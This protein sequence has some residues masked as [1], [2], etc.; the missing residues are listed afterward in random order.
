MRALTVWPLLMV[1]GIACRRAEQRA[2]AEPPIA[3]RDARA[4][5][6]VAPAP[7]GRDSGSPP[8]EA[9]RLRE[10]VRD[11]VERVTRCDEQFFARVDPERI[12][13][14]QLPVDVQAMEA[15]CDP[16]LREFE[17]LV[18]RGALRHP[19]MDEFL[20][21]AA[22][23]SDRYL[24]LCL[25]CKKVGVRDKLPYI[26]ELTALREAIRSDAREV[27]RLAAPVLAIRDD[28]VREFRGMTPTEAARTAHDVLSS[29]EQAIHDLV[30]VPVRETRPVSRYS[31]RL[32]D[33]RADRALTLLRERAAVTDQRILGPAE[34]L[35]H[36]FSSAVNF[37]TGD[38][39]N[40]DQKL[41]A[42]LLRAVHA[43]A[44]EYRRVARRFPDSH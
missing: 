33:R 37:Y 41:G 1:A 32:Q 42:G 38:Y 6:D 17:D 13:Q 2:P 30:E 7:E 20:G 14:W 8:P 22:R 5:S 35:T 25:R 18:A 15:E 12:K 11:Y 27:R 19:A 10:A 3:V 44:R 26:Q 16:I 39:F 4:G 40:A 29:L 24:L 9:Q 23:L 36:A 43:A 21:R 28:E 31:L 34:S